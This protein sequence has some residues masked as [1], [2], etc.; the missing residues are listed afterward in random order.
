MIFIKEFLKLNEE[1]L[2]GF[3]EENNYK[4]MPPNKKVVSVNKYD[5]NIN[6]YN[7]QF[8]LKENEYGRQ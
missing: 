2:I 4:E 1:G 3:N 8:V 5:M 6:I 7:L